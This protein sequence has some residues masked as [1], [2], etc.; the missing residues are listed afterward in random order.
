MIEEDRRNGE[1]KGERALALSTSDYV[2]SA[3]RALLGAAPF[4]G[5][6]L[7]ELAGVIIP[8]QRID[9]VVKFAQVLEGKLSHL[10]QNLV[11]SQVTN[12]HFSDLMEEG[13]RQAAQ[14][15]T[16]ERREYIA[17]LIGTSLSSE[18]VAYIE[19]KHL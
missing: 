3:V 19:S 8:N 11:R 14:S 17:S 16:D 7:T 5:S 12:E 4:V 15:L 9:R 13:L 18:Q 1:E 6:L 10:E 2:A